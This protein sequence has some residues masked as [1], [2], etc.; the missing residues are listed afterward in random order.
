MRIL[1]FGK[2]GQ[3][4]RALQDASAEM[5]TLGRSE[6]DLLQ[7][8]A[9]HAAIETHQPDVVVNAA[10]Y[11]AVDK[12]ETDIGAANRLNATAPAE[13]AEAAAARGSPFIHIST[14]Y[15]FD[16]AVD[17]RLTEDSPM[18]PL[19]H[20]GAS[21]LAGEQAVMGAHA[22]AVILRTSWVFSEYGANFVKTVL[23]LAE[24]RDSLNVVSDQTGGPT[25]ASDIALA[26]L[27]IAGK[28]Y[29]GAPGAGVYHFQGT[30]PVSWAG[31]AEKI[32]EIAGKPVKVSHIK[33]EGYPTP[34]RR[35][36]NTVLD[37]A[38]IEREFGVAPPDWRASLRRVISTLNNEG[39][40]R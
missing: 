1:V 14:D 24:T 6:A 32:F 11:T 28:L 38:R 21:K 18:N 26:I 35:P 7:A 3:V 4:A 27:L 2:N 19:N 34:A 25:A 36:L 31:F 9:A 30:P 29:R 5:I 12:A 39:Q 22:G 10:A 13:M 17:G 40:N 37:C 33:T 16:G 15:V 20:Y 23:R 8:G